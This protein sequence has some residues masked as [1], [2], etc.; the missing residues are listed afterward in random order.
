VRRARRH[1]PGARFTVAYSAIVRLALS[2]QRGEH[3]QLETWLQ[4]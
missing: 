2:A 4:V 1:S 3:D